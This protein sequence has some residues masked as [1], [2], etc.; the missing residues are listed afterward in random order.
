VPD[1]GAADRE[2]VPKVRQRNVAAV[3]GYQAGYMILAAPLAP[4]AAE[5]HHGAGVPGKAQ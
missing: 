4:A 5:V 2:Q 1:Q 3:L